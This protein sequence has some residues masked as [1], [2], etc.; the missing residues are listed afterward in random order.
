M[1]LI[2][3]DIGTSF[4][5]GAALDLEARR[6]GRVRRLP[7][8]EPL[9]GRPPLH[10]EFDPGAIMAAVRELIAALLPDAA[11]CE[12]LLICGLMHGL[13]WADAHGQP[14]SPLTTWQDQRVLEPHP[15]GAGSFFDVLAAQVAPDERRQLGNELRAGQP[16]GL[17]F[18]LAEQRRLPAP[19]LTPASLPDFVAANLCATQP[20]TAPTNAMAHGAL[21]LD[22]MRWHEPLLERLGL[23]GLC[24]PAVQPEGSIVGM[25]E[26]GGRS[27]PCYMP[28]GDFQC[29][30]AGA[31]LAP[32]ELS[33]NIA[34][35]SQ[36]SMLLPERAFGDFQTRPFFDGRFLATITHIPAGRSLSA[37]VALL[38]ELA[39]GQGVALPDPWRYIADA[40]ARTPATRIEADLAFF[41]SSYGDAGALAGL[42][43]EELTVGHLFRAA[44]ERMAATYHHAALRVARGQGWRGL[45]LSGGLAQKLPALRDTIAARFGTPYRFAPSSEDTMLGLL[46]LGLAFSGR[47]SSLGAAARMLASYR[48]AGAE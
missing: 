27:I 28:V 17:L 42:H 13:V 4:I 47:A 15:S 44:F 35:G 25:A 2:G 26:V 6:F 9:P 1:P 8:P 30:L 18:W 5:K 31:L 29:A 16:L 34:T 11:P 33:L 48:E 37:L 3:I 41:S 46:A 14:R 24:W 45:V 43:E 40:A 23:G 32:A 12:G 39:V 7:F 20:T 21:N 36:A 10:R 19:S 22:T 38:S